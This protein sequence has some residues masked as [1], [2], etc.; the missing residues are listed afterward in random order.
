M[1]DT[2]LQSCIAELETRLAAYTFPEIESGQGTWTARDVEINPKTLQK[3]NLPAIFLFVNPVPYVIEY[4]NVAQ[5]MKRIAGKVILRIAQYKQPEDAAIKLVDYLHMAIWKNTSGSSDPNLAGY[6]GNLE[7][8]NAE[9][10]FET[11]PPHVDVSIEFDIV[12]LH[13]IGDPTSIT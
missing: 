1:A 4:E 11:S 2:V 9:I 8:K 5:W 12:V 6:A 10:H 7:M 13:A 3:N